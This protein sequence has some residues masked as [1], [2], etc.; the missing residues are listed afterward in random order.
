MNVIWPFVFRSVQYSPVRVFGRFA[1]PCVFQKQSTQMY[2]AA[3]SPQMRFRLVGVDAYHPEP[4]FASRW[5][6]AFRLPY[7]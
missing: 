7:S 1:G 2:F 5:G 4:H 6:D 3:L